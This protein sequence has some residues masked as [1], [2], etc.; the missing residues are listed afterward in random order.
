MVP[1][2]PRDAFLTP[3]VILQLSDRQCCHAHKGHPLPNARRG[4]KDEARSG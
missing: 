1:I 3:A 2:T 4:G